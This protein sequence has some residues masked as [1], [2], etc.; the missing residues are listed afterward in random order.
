MS[1]HRLLYTSFCSLYHLTPAAFPSSFPAA[2][3]VHSL[4]GL[5][6]ES[7]TDDRGPKAALN[8]HRSNTSLSLRKNNERTKKR[9]RKGKGTERERNFIHALRELSMPLP[10]PP[11]PLPSPP[12]SLHCARVTHSAGEEGASSVVPVGRVAGPSLSL[13]CNCEGKAPPPPPLP[14]E[15]KTSECAG[16]ERGN[17]KQSRKRERTEGRGRSAGRTIPVGAAAASVEHAI[18]AGDLC[19]NSYRPTYR[20]AASDGRVARPPPS[21]P[22]SPCLPD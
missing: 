14:K 19:T 2:S 12:P 17:K 20:P 4:F 16:R 22:P 21:L 8:S 10:P 13:L 3:F 18:A 6:T 5:P 11:L 15:S 1:N 9:K 7:S